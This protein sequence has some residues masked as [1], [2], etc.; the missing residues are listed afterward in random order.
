MTDYQYRVSAVVSVFDD[1]DTMDEDALWASAIEEA[2]DQLRRWT[3]DDDNGV[4]P[5]VE[6][7]NAWKHPVDL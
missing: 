4:Y 7:L 6:Q 2:R 5:E 3:R 1:E